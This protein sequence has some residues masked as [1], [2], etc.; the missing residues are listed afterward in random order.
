M[1]QL[2]MLV[3]FL[4]VGFLN[5]VHSQELAFDS[6]IHFSFDNQVIIERDVDQTADA[7]ESANEDIEDMFSFEE[8]LVGQ[9]KPYRLM[10]TPGEN[11]SE[12]INVTFAL[13][14]SID[15]ASVLVLDT[16]GHLVDTYDAV[17]VEQLQFAESELLNIFKASL[18]ELKPD[19][20]YTYYLRSGELISQQYQF[21]TVGTKEVI[22]S[23]FGDIQGYK[24]SQYDAFRRIYEHML[25]ESGNPDINLLA[26]DLV[27]DGEE[28]EQW[29]YLDLAMGD[30]F[31]DRLWMTPIGNHDVM[32]SDE[33][34]IHSFNFPDN[35]IILLEERNYYIDL[36]NV[37]IAVIDTESPSLFKEQT[38]WL[39]DIMLSE[40]NKFKI[41][42]MHRS[43]YPM[44]YNE[45]Y[46]REF[47]SVFEALGVDLVLSGHDH[48][49][50]RTT[51]K[52]EKVVEIDKGVTYLVGGSGSGSKYYKADTSAKRYWKSL[53]Y[54]EN[55]PVYTVIKATQFQI[56]IRVYAVENDTSLIID[57]FV[58][59]K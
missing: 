35:G 51:V 40:K 20:S 29:N 59:T 21:E 48:I 28:D 47:S 31:D 37:R 10:L 56:L 4:L 38:A 55:N 52:D 24:R 49:Y 23:F 33:N 2:K 25:L 41:V 34:F 57:E 15:S 36:P 3:L 19:T 1:S 7:N 5:N 16:Q 42:L 8:L 18:I 17:F 9:L 43:V 32:G 11:P 53:Y 12:M 27:D 6:V 54:D 39:N 45:N 13:P 44:R 46:I 14:Q 30:Y 22:L 58:L 26:G 50:N